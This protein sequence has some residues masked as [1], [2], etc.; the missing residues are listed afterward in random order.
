MGS[1]RLNK[2]VVIS[3]SSFS[4]D[5]TRTSECIPLIVMSGIVIADLTCGMTFQTLL[6]IVAI[7]YYKEMRTLFSK[8]TAHLDTFSEDSES[9]QRA[10]KHI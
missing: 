3:T 8:S 1:A 2:K 9:S 7:P 5:V 4:F 6:N 10:P